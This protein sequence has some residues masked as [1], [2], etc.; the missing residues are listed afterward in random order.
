VK[1]LQV[2]GLWVGDRISKLEFM[3]YNSFIKNKFEYILYTYNNIANLPEK[4]IVRDAN[5][6]LNKRFIIR[7]RGVGG[8]TNSLGAFSD[9]FRW[10]L[11]YKKGGIYVDS[12]IICLKSFET[13]NNVAAGELDGKSLKVTAGTQYLK[14]E[15]SS[16][17]IAKA[18]KESKNKKLSITPWGSIG[19][20][21][22]NK[23]L[24]R[25]SILDYNNFN[26]NPNNNWNYVL[27]KHK[28]DFFL[29]LSEKENV[30]GIHLWNEMWRINKINKN[31]NFP[32]NSYMAILEKKYL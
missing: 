25:E 4:I 31:Q 32:E 27:Y 14:F 7:G 8:T 23:L 9:L 30:Y 16:P 22:I 10:N 26:A 12:D 3:S 28:T 15:K 21:L 18:L 6:I 29:E 24:P 5:T 20:T 13:K 17:I 1:T 19:P 2:Q 11:L